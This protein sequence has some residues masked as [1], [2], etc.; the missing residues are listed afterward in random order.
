MGIELR[1]Q[2]H[3]LAGVLPQE[4]QTGLLLVGLVEL[5]V[6]AQGLLHF[7]IA[8][9]VA[10]VR[11]PGLTRGLALGERK[12]IDPVHGHQARRKLGDALAHLSVVAVVP[13]H[14][15]SV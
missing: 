3:H 2:L 4:A 10:G 7:L 12:I 9:Q 1:E 8:G 13:R 5:L 14:L 15:R 11:R 6:G